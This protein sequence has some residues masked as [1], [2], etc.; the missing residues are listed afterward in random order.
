MTFGENN[1]GR[2]DVERQ[3]QN[4]GEEQDRREGRELERPIGVQ[5]H[6]EDDEAEH[7]IKSEEDIE[8]GGRNRHHHHQD[9]RNQR[10]RH[11]QGA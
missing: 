4:G 5:A 6:H 3:A 9:E 7:D 1:T 2:G 10:D 8:H 11:H